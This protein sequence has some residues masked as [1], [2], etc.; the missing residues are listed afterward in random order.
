M[1]TFLEN[2]SG[3]PKT[4]LNKIIGNKFANLNFQ[5]KEKLWTV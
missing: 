2:W 5:G 4:Y 3:M 1:L